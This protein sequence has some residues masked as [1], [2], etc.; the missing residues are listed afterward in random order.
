MRQHGP[1]FTVSPAK[2]ASGDKK[3]QGGRSALPKV[4]PEVIRDR[5]VASERD[6]GRST[7]R[8]PKVVEAVEPAGFAESRGPV[9]G[10]ERGVDLA[11]DLSRVQRIADA[12]RIEQRRNPHLIQ[13]Y[14][15]VADGGPGRP[16]ESLE[17]RQSAEVTATVSGIE[18]GR[19]QCSR[20][21]GSAPE[22]EV[23]RLLPEARG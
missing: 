13:L 3:R 9:E 12:A 16:A 10:L 5:S 18:H 1:R 23:L 14:L 19:D 8:A 15:R 22:V 20:R 2:V 21:V 7:Q 4:L 11:D 6:S 17:E